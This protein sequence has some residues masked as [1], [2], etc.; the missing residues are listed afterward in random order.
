MLQ[1]DLNLQ[2]VANNYFLKI[3]LH[4]PADFENAENAYLLANIGADTAE[5]ERNFAKFCQ[6]QLAPTLL[7]AAWSCV[8]L[9]PALY[10]RAP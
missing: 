4:N 3:Q 10:K 8:A 6:E 7:P 1:N 2:N 9:P 5:H